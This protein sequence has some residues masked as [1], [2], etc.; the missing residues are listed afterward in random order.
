[1]DVKQIASIMNDVTSEVLGKDGIVV[2]DLSNIVDVGTE[3]FD[4]NS[5]DNYVKSLIDHI[6]RVVFVNRPYRGNVPSIMKDAWEY[7]SILEKITMDKL[8]EAVENESWDLTDGKTYDPNVFHKPQVSAKFFNKRVTFEIDMSITERQVKESFSS[9][10]QL[11]GFLSMIYNAIDKSM[12][13]KLDSLVM[14][15]ID[16]LMAQTIH[17][18]EKAENPAGD[19]K[20]VKL[21]VEY[22]ERFGKTLEED[23]ALTDPD[24]I[25]FAV[26]MM[27][28]YIDRLGTIS[29]L[30]NVGG[31]DRFTPKDMLNVVMLS[32]FKQSANVYLQ[33]DTFHNEYTALPNSDTV[34]YWQGS[35]MNYSFDNTSSIKVELGSDHEDHVEKT[36]ILAVMFDRDACGVTNLNRRVTTQYNPKGE[37]FNNFYK[38]DAGYF[39]DLNENAVV[40]ML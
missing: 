21:L 31:K 28:L 29:T 27:G 34:P 10:E 19:V 30:F 26:L 8:P 25:K 20:V 7:G 36:G 11:N 24:F 3:I 12:T 1:M 2:E 13:V 38:F 16:T 4:S 32:E 39:I 22:N 17:A 23:K 40:F 33:S 35:G 18:N 14:R 9:P 15:T 5:V 37:F 6:G